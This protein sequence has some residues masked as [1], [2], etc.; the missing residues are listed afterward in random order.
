MIVTFCSICGV[1]CIAII[2][3]FASSLVTYRLRYVKRI[4]DCFPLFSFPF[5]YKPGNF[6]TFRERSVDVE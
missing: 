3:I 1:E 6:D 2:V 5:W 4:Y